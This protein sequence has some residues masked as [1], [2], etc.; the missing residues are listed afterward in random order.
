MSNREHDATVPEGTER[1]SRA[2]EL[3]RVHY[4]PVPHTSSRTPETTGDVVEGELL[5]ED[6]YRRLTSQRTQAV[7]RYRGYRRD[8]VT[9]YRGVKTAVTHERTKTLVRHAVAYPIAGVGVVV[10][11]W[12]DTHGASRYERMMLHAEMEGNHERLL[13]WEARD[14]AEK[15]RRHQRVMDW[16]TAPGRWITAGV[17]G[18]TGLAGFLLVLGVILA[19]NSGDIADVIAPITAV[20]DAVAFTVWFLTAYGVFLLLGGTVAGLFYLYQQGRKHGEAPSWLQARA[21]GAASADT[22]LDESMIMN[23]LRNLGHPALNKKFKEGWGHTIQPTWVQPPL[24]VGHG[25]EFALR[26]P[27]GVPATSINARKV[28]LAHNLGRRP[29][30]VWVEVEET[31]PMAMKCLVLDP[32]ALREPVPDYP[33]ADS[34]DTDFWTGFPVGIDAR[35]NPVVTPVFERNFVWAGIMGSGKS[36][37]VLDLLAGAVLD[38]VV[39]IDV[40]CFAENNDYEWLRPVASTLSMGDTAANVD[41]CMAHIQALQ[42]SLA[43]RGRLLRE[44]GIDSVTRQ[45]AEKD[46]RLRPRI[47]VIDECQSFFRQ[48]KPEDRRELVNLM[49]RFYSAARKYGIVLGFATPTPSDQSLPR[50]LVAVTT[51]KSC[52]AIGDKTR[53]NVVLGEK[54]YENGLSALELK[55]AVKKGGTIV[56]L[57]DVGTSVTVG[58]MDTPGL[59]RS[60]NLTHQQKTAIVARGVEL[61]G[62]HG[63]RTPIEPQRRDLLTDVAAVLL[64]GE[65]KAKATDVCARLREHAPD[66]RPYVGLTAE[67]LRDQLAGYGCKV[68]KVGVLMVFTERVREALAAREGGND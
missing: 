4:L 21:T 17:V 55:P 39:E 9:L 66:H 56:A 2:S 58:F 45:A 24:P 6:E 16:I 5:T 57:N 3:A 64:P 12:R 38:P 28:V 14:V 67:A 63:R 10:R 41:A 59:L 30:E 46:E 68:T 18:L 31:D 49:I 36:T 22:A 40:F 50:D 1:E 34:G 60:Y 61:R 44:Y 19:V 37:Q 29:E 20:L 7:E 48:D 25:W 35:W 26:L 43:E 47:V 53:N 13:E 15:Q 23:A 54:A 8:A 52:F 11:R 65:D 32:G 33:L 27:G 42:D 62:G 51:N